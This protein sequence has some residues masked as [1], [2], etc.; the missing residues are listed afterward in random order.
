MSGSNEKTGP[1]E[2][3]NAASETKRDLI[4]DSENP[5]LAEKGY[6]PFL[7][8]RSFSFHLDTILA[9]NQKNTAHWLDNIV[10]FDYYRLSLPKRRRF[11]WVK[12]DADKVA[13]FMEKFGCTK[14]TAMDWLKAMAPDTLEEIMALDMDSYIG[15]GGKKRATKSK[16]AK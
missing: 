1:F 5:T 11:G 12:K 9:A 10:Q 13:T 16:R 15:G 3:I 7:T 14:K 8:N 6:S 4:R 2:F